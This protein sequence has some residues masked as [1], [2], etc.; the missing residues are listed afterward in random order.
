MTPEEFAERMQKLS[1][2]G[3]RDPERA[4]RDA[5][6]LLCEVLEQL[7]YGQ[8]IEIYAQMTRWCG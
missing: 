5:D 6:D 7:G 1:D 8:G 2:F 4:H 3:E